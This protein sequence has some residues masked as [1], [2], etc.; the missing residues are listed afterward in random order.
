MD[1]ET[2]QKKIDATPIAE[3]DIRDPDQAY[4]KDI[5]EFKQDL[6]LIFENA[7]IYNQPD[8]IYFK[9]SQQLEALIQ[10]ML[11][12]LRDDPTIFKKKGIDSKE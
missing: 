8:T 9:Y 3:G 7:R 11:K 6:K 10:P 1:L 12:R 2:I 5:E 4:Y